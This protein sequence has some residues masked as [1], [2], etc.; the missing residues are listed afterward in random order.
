MADL[1]VALV[2]LVLAY[3]TGTAIENAHFRNLIRREK[4]LLNLPVHSAKVWSSPATRTAIVTGVVVVS[5]DYF[6]RFL[7]GL[8]NIF[9]GRV[10]A[11]ESLLDRARR[12]AI[13]RMKVQ[14]KSLGAQEIAN[15]RMETVTITRQMGQGGAGAIEI[16]VYGTALI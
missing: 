11:Y 5:N 10:S 4:E 1:V 15:V 6:K 16:I 7:A 8:R 13:I 14:A 9:G 12:E 2:M 3:F